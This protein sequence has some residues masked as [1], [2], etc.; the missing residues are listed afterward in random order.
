MA[1]L[2]ATDVQGF[3]A[4]PDAVLGASV[5]AVRS[6]CGWHIAPAKIETEVV[7]GLGPALLLPTLHLTAVTSI[8]RDGTEVPSGWKM[9]KNGVVRGP[10]CADEYEVTFE[11]GYAQWPDDLLAVIADAS[12]VPVTGV[13]KQV[14]SVSYETSAAARSSV[15]FSP[16]QFAILDRYKIPPRP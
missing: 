6:H 14:G 15:A 2:T 1:E 5:A 9:R 3:L 10:F 8:K 16:A 12:G 13:L 7:D 11:H 4:D